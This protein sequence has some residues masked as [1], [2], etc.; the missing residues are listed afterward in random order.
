MTRQPI[1]S[2]QWSEAKA[3]WESDDKLT[4]ADL[5]TSLGISKQAVAKRAT[6]ENWQRRMQS[7]KVVAKAYREADKRTL[8]IALPKAT[9][10]ENP[11]GSGPPVVE[12]P[13]KSPPIEHVEAEPVD[14]SLMTL[15]Q[16]AEAMAVAKRAEILT[17]HRNEANA[18]RTNLYKSIQTQNFDLGKCSKINAEAMQIIHNVERK[19][20]G[21]DKIEER[22]P[23]VI[24]DRG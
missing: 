10:A 23:V 15:E 8:S 18:L 22:P 24:L 1:T 3:L 2:E 7:E 17:R 13:L 21:I 14:S 12:S 19:A 4:F 20:W 5:G 9:F 11:S 6:K 16:R